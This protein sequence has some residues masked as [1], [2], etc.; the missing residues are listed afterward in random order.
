MEDTQHLIIY[1]LKIDNEVNMANRRN[2]IKIDNILNMS[3]HKY[4]SSGAINCATVLHV[5]QNLSQSWHY[6]REN[7]NTKSTFVRPDNYI[8]QDTE[9]LTVLRQLYNVW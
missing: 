5:V 1:F 6:F 4:R 9:D 3:N 2:F 7:Y 8:Q